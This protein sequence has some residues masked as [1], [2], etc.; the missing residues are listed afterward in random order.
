MSATPRT[1]ASSKDEAVAT[2]LAALPAQEHTRLVRL[3]SEAPHVVARL[4]P[5]A[6]P[7]HKATMLRALTRGIRGVRLRTVTRGRT[8]MTCAKWIAEFWLAVDEARRSGR[9]AGAR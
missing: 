9:K 3:L 6:K 5:G 4:I 7:P 1:C 8:R 2:V